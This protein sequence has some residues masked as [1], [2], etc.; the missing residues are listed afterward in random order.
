MVVY[1]YT[2]ATHC[3][4]IVSFA[5]NFAVLYCTQFSPEMDFLEML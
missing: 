2:D 4:G 3:V 5:I 1:T